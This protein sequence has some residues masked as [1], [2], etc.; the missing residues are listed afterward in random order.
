M[1]GKQYTPKQHCMNTKAWRSGN[2]ITS[3]KICGGAEETLPH[4]LD[5]IL[6]LANH[7]WRRVNKL[8]LASH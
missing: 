7:L 6:H 5:R 1:G 8:S 3:C 2:H 4:L